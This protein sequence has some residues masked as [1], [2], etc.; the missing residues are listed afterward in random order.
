MTKFSYYTKGMNKKTKDIDKDSPINGLTVTVW[1]GNLDQ[2][3]ESGFPKMIDFEVLKA[4]TFSKAV[5]LYKKQYEKYEARSFDWKGH[6]FGCMKF[7]WEDQSEN[8][9]LTVVK[10]NYL[11]NEIAE[12]NMEEFDF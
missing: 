3:D 10:L 8:N 1:T 5:D 11:D 7:Y 12:F 4:K 9:F 2:R 6:S